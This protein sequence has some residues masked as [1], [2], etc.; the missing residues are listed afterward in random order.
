M[1]VPHCAPSKVE[2]A[3]PESV[4]PRAYVYIGMGQ[5]NQFQLPAPC[6]LQHQIPVARSSAESNWKLHSGPLASSCSPSLRYSQRPHALRH[7][8]GGDGGHSYMETRCEAGEGS[9]VVPQVQRY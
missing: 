8:D 1:I 7:R 2:V 6:L 5:T 3:V 4:S 9:E